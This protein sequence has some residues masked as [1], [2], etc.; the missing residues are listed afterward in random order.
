VILIN[1]LPHREA[2]RK[3]RKQAFF[4]GIAA[5]AALGVL[6]AA[7]WLAWVDH[8]IAQQN[9]RNNFLQQEIAKLEEQIKDVAQLK[10]EIDALRARQKSVEDLQVDR[11]IPVHI[12]NELVAHTPDGVYYTQMRHDGSNLVVTGFAQSQERVSELLRAAS[13]HS[14]WFSKPDL[15]EIKATGTPAALKTSK[16]IYDFQ[17]RLSVKRPQEV[18]PA[19]AAASGAAQA[20]AKG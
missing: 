19:D 18:L 10:Q 7:L 15:I 2:A 1:L 8:S 20:G 12:L 14:D 16:R 4:V 11:N 3:K 9:N 13:S 5:A 6:V 17:M